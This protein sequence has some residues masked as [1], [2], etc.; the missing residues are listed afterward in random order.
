MHNGIKYVSHGTQCCLCGLALALALADINIA[1]LDVTYMLLL[2]SA[3][4]VCPLPHACA[5]CQE[6]AVADDIVTHVLT[7]E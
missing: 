6:L 1:I 4:C 3:N 7:Q 5:A 2:H